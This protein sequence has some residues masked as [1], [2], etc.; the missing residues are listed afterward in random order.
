MQRWLCAL[1]APALC[2]FVSAGVFAQDKTEAKRAVHPAGK[3][4]NMDVRN[5]KNESLGHIEDC[6]INLKDGKAVYVVM[7]RG[8]VLGLGGTMFAIAPEALSLAANGE[9]LMLN[10]TNADFENAKGFDQNSWPSQPD[11]RW[12]KA[13]STTRVEEQPVRADAAVKSNDNLARISAITGLNV[14]GRGDDNKEAV[15]GTIYD[16]ALNCNTHKVAYAAVHHGG[17]LGIGGKLIAVPWDA[18]VLKAPALDPQRRAFF[19]NATQRDLENAEGFTTDNWPEQ[20]NARFKN[21]RT[22]K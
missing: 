3:I 14:Y 18:L 16:L 19:I 22:E 11:R 6:V 7:A 4:M 15:V 21:L 2:L 9:Y 17:T 20:P 10:A 5:S 13:A 8:Q 1:A 12:G